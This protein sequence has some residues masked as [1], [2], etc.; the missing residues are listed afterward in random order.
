MSWT[1][2]PT[3][4]MPL[5]AM[6]LAGWAYS[7]WRR[8]VNVV[9]AMWPMFFLAATIT[10]AMQGQGTRAAVLTLLVALWAMRLALHLLVRNHGK[11]EDRRY[12]A[13]RRNNSPGFAW[14]SLYI[15]FGLQALLA[16]FISLPLFVAATSG[17]PLNVLDALGVAAMLGGLLFEATA[18][19]QLMRFKSRPENRGR[20]LDT[21]LWAWSRH[22]NYFGEACIW[23]GF[24]LIGVAAGSYWSLLAPIVM[25]GL[26]L[27][28]SGV[29]LLEKDIHERRP[30]YR[31]YILRTSAFVPWPP[32]SCRRGAG[33]ETT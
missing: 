31:D 5:L 2:W 12:Q 24:G 25:T 1:I 27:K 28:V 17:S 18:D 11:P 29:S 14:K 7:V 23:L 4:L 30:D 26:L 20:V 19:R 6:V 3:S 32:N 16:W 13:I 9:D 21:G 15:V 10:Y 22:P 8:N 33:K